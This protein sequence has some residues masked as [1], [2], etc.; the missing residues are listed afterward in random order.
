MI[1]VL[2]N[3]AYKTQRVAKKNSCYDQDALSWLHKMKFSVAFFETK[4]R[5]IEKYYCDLV[6]QV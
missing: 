3:D 2:Y 6:L 5:P 1:K 4:S